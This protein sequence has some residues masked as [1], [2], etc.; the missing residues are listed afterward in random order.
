MHQIHMEIIQLGLV[1]VIV[2]LI[3]I[4]GLIITQ[5]LVFLFALQHQISMLIMWQVVVLMFVQMGLLRIKQQEDVLQ[6]VLLGIMVVIRHQ[7]VLETVHLANLLIICWGYALQGAQLTQF[8]MEIQIP[9]TVHKYVPIQHI[10]L[11]ILWPK[12]A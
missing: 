3:L 5:G 4:L 8:S 11:E 2:L 1:S 7:D 12:S 10:V 6:H 9:I